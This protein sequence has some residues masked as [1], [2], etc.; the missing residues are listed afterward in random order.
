LNILSSEKRV[1]F[2]SRE[3]DSYNS[4][5]CSFNSR[6]RVDSKAE[7]NLNCGEE[8]RFNCRKEGNLKAERG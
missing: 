3:E 5:Y 7:G 4:K 6:K 2:N 8:S 1:S